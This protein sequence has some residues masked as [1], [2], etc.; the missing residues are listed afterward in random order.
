MENLRGE[1]ILYR[2][3]DCNR[4]YAEMGRRALKNGQLIS[5]YEK[6]TCPSNRQAF[7]FFKYNFF[8]RYIF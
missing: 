5:L 3:R 7:T 4:F 2:R 6:G 1:I 8:T